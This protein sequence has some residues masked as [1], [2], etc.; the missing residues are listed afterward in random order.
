[1]HEFAHEVSRQAQSK[2]DFKAPSSKLRLQYIERESDHGNSPDGFL[3][4]FALGIDSKG[5]FLVRKLV[6]QQV[7]E[8]TKISWP[9]YEKMMGEDSSLLPTNVNYWFDSQDEVRLVRTLDGQ[10]RAYLGDK[11]RPLDNFDLF[12]AVSPVLMGSQ[13]KG[14]RIESI[15]ITETRFYIKAFCGLTGLS[16]EVTPGDVIQA[17]VAITNS[18]VG[19]AQI[20][21]EP[22]VFRVR[23]LN[24][25][26]VPDVG[27]KRRHVGRG[28]GDMDGAEEY[29]SDATRRADDEA[30]WRKVVDVVRGSFEE[31][32]FNKIV[33]K[34]KAAADNRI[35]S[36][37]ASLQEVKEVV[38]NMYSLTDTEGE[39]ILQNLINGGDLSQY[40]LSNAI[41]AAAASPN[42]N[43]ER[44][45]ELERFGGQVIELS[46]KDWK[47]MVSA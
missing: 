35:P 45:T 4:K 30:F 1:M 37:G 12:K 33:E 16:K 26:I 28:S 46:Q 13:A 31:A 32:R 7:A 40:G 43:Y 38:Q 36:G 47:E 17:G 27:L 2:R 14:M 18:E 11:Y 6:H 23:C 24:G 22:A 5:T 41:T 29:F 42:V 9:Y 3:M 44:A 8:R 20:A 25:L 39:M 19:F 15:Q 21:V 10:A 34:M